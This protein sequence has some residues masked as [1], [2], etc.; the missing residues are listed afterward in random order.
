M[1]FRPKLRDTKRANDAAIRN[2]A[3]AFGKDVVAAT[4]NN[5]PDKQERSERRDLE[6]PVKRGIAELLQSHPRVQLAM[7]CNSG[8]AYYT[9]MA[10][11]DV[12]VQ[13]IYF[14]KGSSRSEPMR[15]P[16]FIGCMKDGRMLAIEAKE[17]QWRGPRT[18]HE[19]EQDNFL[20]AVRQA[21]GLAGFATSVDMALRI[22]NGD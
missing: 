10:G 5:I 11:K 17:P 4:L 2:M 12:P 7:R 6:G 1:K 9:N 22:L 21:G 18:T 8:M 13:F 19:R 14:V 20:L 15:V 3:A 16:D